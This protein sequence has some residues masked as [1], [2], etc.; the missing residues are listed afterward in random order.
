MYFIR[1]GTVEVLVNDVRV[2]QLF[3]GAVFGE[4]ALLSKV[5][6]TA[7]VRAQTASAVYKLERSKLMRILT[8]Y[9]DVRIKM[10]KIYTERMERIKCEDSG[11]RKGS[12]KLK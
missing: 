11:G 8:A 4:I 1:T 6:R 9:D 7:T 12:P 5:P 10:D 3:D 2:S